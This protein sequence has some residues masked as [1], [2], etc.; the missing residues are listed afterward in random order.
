MAS[1]HD[2]SDARILIQGLFE[3]ESQ[4]KSRSLPRHPSDRSFPEGFGDFLSILRR[5]NGYG[6]IWVEVVDV[7]EGQ[8]AMERRV[9]GRRFGVQIVEAMPK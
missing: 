1:E 3:F 7:F 2:S 8:K 9:N 5:G 4:V 6:S